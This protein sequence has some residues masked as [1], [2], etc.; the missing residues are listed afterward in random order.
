MTDSKT[1][2]AIACNYWI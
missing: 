2:D 1:I